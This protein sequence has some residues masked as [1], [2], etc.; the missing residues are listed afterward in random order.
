MERSKL[1][2]WSLQVQQRSSNSQIS[3]RTSLPIERVTNLLNGRRFSGRFSFLSY[4]SVTSLREA[5]LHVR[6]LDHCAGRPDEPHPGRDATQT[7]TLPADAAFLRGRLS[8]PPLFLS[9]IA[10]LRFAF[11]ATP[12]S[13]GHFWVVPV[14]VVLEIGSGHCACPRDESILVD[15][16][17]TR[18]LALVKMTLAIFVRKIQRGFPERESGFSYKSYS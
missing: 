3:G 7:V 17:I 8:P 16:I 10:L 2:V 4:I 6:L 13:W 18:A 11:P 14:S 12:A 15:V 5:C 1:V 9:L